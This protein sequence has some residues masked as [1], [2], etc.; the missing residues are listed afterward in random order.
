[1]VIQV[2]LIELRDVCMSYENLP[3]VLHVSAQI[4]PGDYVIVVGEN[5]SGKSTLIKGILGLRPLKSGKIDFGDGLLQTQIGYLPQQTA[6]QRDFPA[7]VREVVLSGLLPSL[8]ARPF[9]SK[10]DKEKARDEMDKLGIGRL[11]KK[12]YGELSGGQQQR[13]LLARAMCATRKLLLLD[14]PMSG[15]D[16]MATAELYQQIRALNRA[17]GVAVIMVS[18]DVGGALK[19]ATKVLCMHQTMAFFGTVDEF[20][21][22]HYSD[23]LT[24]GDYHHV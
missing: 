17:R 5:G 23:E 24:G 15:L 6:A 16:P 1:M 8:G 2:A 14:E 19:D 12:C 11:A 18:H 7:S 10:A 21:H 3:A 13:V 4:E 20:Y 22:T 9:Y